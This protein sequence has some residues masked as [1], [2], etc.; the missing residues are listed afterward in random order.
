MAK[1]L[2]IVESPAK[3]KT[4]GKFLG[5]GYVVE[6]SVGHIRDLPRNAKDIPEQYKGHKWS[7]IGIDTDNGFAPIYIVPQEKKEQI[8]KLKALLK[9][10]DELFLATDEDREGESISWHL[11]EVLNPKV[12][13]RRMVFHEIT[14]PAIQAAV[15]NPREID[16]ALVDAQETRRIL[17][18]LYGY[19]ISPVL[20]RKVAPRLSAGRVQSVATR[21]VVERERERM[22]FR[23]G[24]YWDLQASLGASGS[25][26]DANLLSVDGKRVASGK[27]FDAATGQA[28][29]PDI[30][31]LDEAQAT[32]LADGL[33]SSAFVVASVTEKSE[34]RRPQAPFITS[35]LQ[36][37]GA[38]KLGISAKQ[39]MS[40]AQRLYEQGYITYMRTD[41]T[42]LSDAAIAAARKQAVALYGPDAVPESPRRYAGKV[43]NAQEA[44][45]AIRPA[46]DVFKTP[47]EVAGELLGG[48][49]KLYDLIWKRTIAS[50]MADARL[51]IVN[52]RI[53]ATASSGEATV[54]AASGS[55]I[56][57][58]GFMRAYVE[59]S[60]NP[61]DALANREKFLPQLTQGATLPCNQLTP[62]SHT[63]SPPARYTEASLVKRLEEAGIGRPSTYASIL[64]RIQAANYV[65]KKSS[66]LI[67]TWTAFAVTGLLEQHFGRFVDYD[68]T[69]KLE[70]DLDEIANRS[71][72]RVEWLKNF[73]F[74]NGSMGLK[75]LVGTVGLDRIDA[76]AI[77]SIAIGNDPDGV[78]VVVRVG[79][80][81]PYIQRGEDRVS[82]NDEMPPDEVTVDVA[83]RLLTGPKS[84]TPIGSDPVSGHPV[85]VKTGR[86]GPY[87][88][89]GD[90]ESL[91]AG[92]KPKMSSLFKTMEPSSVTLDLALQLLQIPRTVGVDPSTDEEIV[93]ANGKFGPYLRKGT[94][95]RSLETEEAILSI[96]LEQAL[97]IY[98]KPKEFR[99]GRGVAKPPLA[100]FADD[101]VS[102]RP[103]V[104]KE[105]Q[106]GAY[107]TDGETN[108]TV[109][110]GRDVEDLTADEV[111]ELLAD[112]RAKGPAPKKAAKRGAKK[113]SK[114]KAAGDGSGIESTVK[115]TVKGAAK[116]AAAKKVAKK[117]A[118]KS[119]G[120]AV[121]KAP[122]AAE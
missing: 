99:R 104:V 48:D 112:K 16:Y 98:S 33:Q 103:V 85:F 102:G 122:D 87:V 23:S 70:D 72:D 101:P 10:A 28:T 83:L 107:I 52:A 1:K 38:R 5:S 32:A 26:F 88:Q 2:V 41:S 3:A 97:E 50:Q 121:K 105:G 118:K 35:T 49:F 119:A 51:N 37:E 64:E 54:F 9:E 110:R 56:A 17:D 73:Y 60:D 40:I 11:K 12:P 45:E 24:T 74:G 59:G 117:T 22:R 42:T 69:A 4:I 71:K 111:Y 100:S 76:A 89:L 91:G 7:S 109:P 113:A 90:V 106:Y 20:W 79:Q 92:V 93:A 55:T 95:S 19:E 47:E 30:V 68:F 77:N 15:A 75:E 18:R 43:K 65:F 82:L 120:A 53:E 66:A 67:P 58:P 31:V 36:Q 62:Q 94:D 115:R 86:Y 84:D 114:A 80:Y 25:V 39:V 57:F 8:R 61:D 78:P 14:K 6:A 63:T 96:T 34:A 81:G 29:N 108:V 21:L 44:H 27:D 46:G 13:I 116:K